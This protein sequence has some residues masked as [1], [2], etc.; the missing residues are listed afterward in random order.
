LPR[1]PLPTKTKRRTHQQELAELRRQVDALRGQLHRAQRLATLG[2]MTAMVAHEFNNIL[3]PIINY[4]QLAQRDPKMVDKAVTRAA[5]GGQRASEICQAIL[6]LAR[7]Q[8]TDP[9]EVNLRDLIDQTL[10][11]MAREPQKDGIDL[12]VDVE[13]DL[14]VHAA[15]AGVQQVLLNLLMNARSAVLTRPAPRQVRITA[16]RRDGQVELRVADNGPGIAPSD[17]SSIFQ[18]F[19]S[20]KE[21]D[22]QRG[23][24]HGL[25]LTICREIVESMGGRI[26]AD[27]PPRAGATFRVTLPE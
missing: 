7:E 9:A 20:T 24:G 26:A 8:A 21:R 10:S 11:A 27:S 18:P 17:L 22:P 4:A 16:R 15:R 12:T 23:D 3:T 25:G 6:G 19:F 5:E 2:T 13:D 14:T 1:T